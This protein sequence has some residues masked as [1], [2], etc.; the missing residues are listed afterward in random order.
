MNVKRFI[1]SF[2]LFLNLFSIFSATAAHHLSSTSLFS[3]AIVGWTAWYIC[4]GSK[5]ITPDAPIPVKHDDKD[6]D[7]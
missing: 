2:L 5:K 3:G 4:I 6:D 1:A 7:E